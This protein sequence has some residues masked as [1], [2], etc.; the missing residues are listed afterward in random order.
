MDIT[1][2]LDSPDS[3]FVVDTDDP[4]DGDDLQEDMFERIVHRLGLTPHD[5]VYGFA[6]RIQEGG[7]IRP[8]Y[9]VLAD[10]ATELRTLRSLQNPLVTVVYSASR[11]RRCSRRRRRGASRANILY[12]RGPR[13]P[14]GRGTSRRTQLNCR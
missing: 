9:A 11:P 4:M 1:D 6:P 7:D 14:E 2:I 8:E 3:Q 10:A 12:C 13:D 5:T